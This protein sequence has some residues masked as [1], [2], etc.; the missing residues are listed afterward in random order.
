MNEPVDP[1]CVRQMGRTQEMG[2]PSLNP[3]HRHYYTVRSLGYGGAVASCLDCGSRLGMLRWTE[4]CTDA[5]LAPRTA[6]HCS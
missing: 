3:D 5:V 4:P 1:R 6:E 2:R